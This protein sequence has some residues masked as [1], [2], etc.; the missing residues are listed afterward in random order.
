MNLATRST[1]GAMLSTSLYY[2]INDDIHISDIRQAK[3]EYGSIVALGAILGVKLGI[4]I[5]LLLGVKKR[6]DLQA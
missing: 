6:L 5:A 4:P 1:M 3:H 2:M